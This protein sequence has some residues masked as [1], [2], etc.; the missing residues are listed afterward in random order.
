MPSWGG[1]GT[2]DLSRRNASLP[3]QTLLET[4]TC[5][6]ARGLGERLGAVP[7]R[8]PSTD[9]DVSRSTQGLMLWVR[10]QLG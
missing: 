5:W 9:R 1:G 2:L 4:S 7:P 8:G 10:A 6:A 3:S